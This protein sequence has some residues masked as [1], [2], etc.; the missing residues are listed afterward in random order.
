MLSDFTTS[1]EN[2][3]YGVKTL[4]GGFGVRYEVDSLWKVPAYF[5]RRTNVIT[6]PSPA[7]R[8][9][10]GEGA[11][12]TPTVKQAPRLARNDNEWRLADAP[13]WTSEH[14]VDDEFIRERRMGGIASLRKSDNGVS[15]RRLSPQ[16][17]TAKR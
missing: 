13:P 9:N 11:F 7:G 8:E 14:N 5:S 16:F 12:F 6:L 15:G 2:Q 4:P 17:C 10:E 1:I 3:D